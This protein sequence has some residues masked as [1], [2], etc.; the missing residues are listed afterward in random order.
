MH[1]I[2]ILGEHLHPVHLGEDTLTIR[3]E[4]AIKVLPA[5]RDG[6]F[7]ECK[8]VMAKV[9]DPVQCRF[10]VHIPRVIKP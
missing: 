2:L 5:L 4:E 8:V 10:L 6:H 9:F 3:F 7:A 1:K